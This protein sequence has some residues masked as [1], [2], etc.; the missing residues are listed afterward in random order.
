MNGDC[1]G[2]R[3]PCERTSDTSI[4]N[5]LFLLI[6]SFLGE[7]KNSLQG[8]EE[9][10]RSLL[11]IPNQKKIYIKRNDSELVSNAAVFISQAVTF[12][13]KDLRRK[14]GWYLSLKKR[15]IQ[16]WK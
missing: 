6:Q 2:L 11:N 15:V 12:N 9:P 14:I 7:K 1:E 10:R 16:P 13:H 5:L 8:L 4:K 3:G